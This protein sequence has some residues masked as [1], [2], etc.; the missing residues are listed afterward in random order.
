MTQ[1]IDDDK[2]FSTQTPYKS[3]FG[4]TELIQDSQMD[5]ELFSFSNTMTHAITNLEKRIDTCDD[6]Y[7]L[8]TTTNQVREK[9]RESQV[10]ATEQLL[11]SFEKRLSH[12]EEVLNNIPN[13]IKEIIADEH[14]K[15]DFQ[16]TIQALIDQYI[17]ETNDQMDLLEQ[18][19]VTQEKLKQKNMKTVKRDLTLL[20]TIPK[21]D[22]DITD[23]ENQMVSLKNSQRTLTDIFNS[24][25]I[26]V[27]MTNEN[28]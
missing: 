25:Q 18:A 9:E 7:R 13:A 21:D 5:V 3:K 6:I 22:S 19:I 10:A 24:V 20:K 27:N 23:L 14:A 28:S 1:I 8:A 16:K 12:V 4:K 17:K 2:I 26:D 15:N 11:N